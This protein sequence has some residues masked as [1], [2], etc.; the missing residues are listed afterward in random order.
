MSLEENI[1]ELNK[2]LQK[3]NKT[4]SDLAEIKRLKNNISS[5]KSR[6]RAKGKLKG[7]DEK[8]TVSG[9][10]IQVLPPP[11]PEKK[12]G[13][14]TNLA[15]EYYV[16]SVLYRLGLN[17]YLTLGNKKSIDI[18][19]E[20]KRGILTVDVKGMASATNWPLDN[21]K[22]E[23]KSK[24]HFIVLVS[25]LNKI[26]NPDVLPAVYIV[27]SEKIEGFFYHNPKG[28][29]QVVSFG[30]MKK[31]GSKYKDNWELLM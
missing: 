30:T 12:L 27:P 9:E 7:I 21:F 17:A 23:K 8:R 18:I 11:I 13:Y 31:N 1:K 28:N 3:A 4:S 26:N 19:I 15:S 22:T 20:H 5:I 10:K 24:N 29:R 14:N 25:Y 2:L 16:L 6:M